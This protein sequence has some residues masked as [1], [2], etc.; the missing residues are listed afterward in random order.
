MGDQ[1]W[2]W[3]ARRVLD[4]EVARYVISGGGVTLI[5]VAGYFVLLEAGVVYTAANIASLVLSKA[6]GYFLNKF[7]VYRSECKGWVQMAGELT[8]YILARGFTGLFDFFGV[9]V[10]VEYVGMGEQISK[11]LLMA[12]VE[13]LNYILG[14]KAVLISSKKKSLPRKFE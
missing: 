10:L 12:V 14:K 7:W 3:M 4:N 11:L 5:N 2:K 6:A 13:I 9:M 8:R 1:K